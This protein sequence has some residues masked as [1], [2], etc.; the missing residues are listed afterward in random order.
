[1]GIIALSAQRKDRQRN[2]RIITG[3]EIH[4][5]ARIKGLEKLSEGEIRYLQMFVDF[6][7]LKKSS[8]DSMEGGRSYAI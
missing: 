6:M 8:E 4:P 3:I 1:M 7:I 5:A 2:R